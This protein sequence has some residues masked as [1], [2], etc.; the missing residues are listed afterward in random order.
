MKK[1][2]YLLIG[3]LFLYALA[4][5]NTLA[6]N[7]ALQK[8]NNSSSISKFLEIELPED[9]N[10]HIDI[11]FNLIIKKEYKNAFEKLFINSPIFQKDT[12]VKNILDQM[13]KSVDLYGHIKNYEIIDY[14]IV[15]KYYY[16]VYA[17]GLNQKL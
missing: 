10:S 5:Y 4:N 16:R 2:F 17:I 3:F 1:K 6:Q 11:F 15:G 14:K 12:E 13:K 7:N 9:I 8:A